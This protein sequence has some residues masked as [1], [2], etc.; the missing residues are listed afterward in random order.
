MDDAALDP[1][2]RL[3]EHGPEYGQSGTPQQSQGRPCTQRMADA[4]QCNM[5]SI[6]VFPEL[7]S[8]R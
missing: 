4:G 7:T 1:A 6:Y 8:V 3:P 5:S 2:G